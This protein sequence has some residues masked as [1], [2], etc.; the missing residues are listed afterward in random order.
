MNIIAAEELQIAIDNY[1]YGRA[2]EITTDK[3]LV[4]LADEVVEK[5]LPYIHRLK[6]VIERKHNVIQE[7]MKKKKK[8]F[9]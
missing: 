1:L 2:D 9:T 3:E 5:M 6:E 7:L 4:N 8:V